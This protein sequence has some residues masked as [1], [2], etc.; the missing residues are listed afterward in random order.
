[1]SEPRWR[2]VGASVVGT[3]HTAH[4][5][6]CQ[7]AHAFDR[8]DLPAQGQVLLA[9]VADG[10]GSAKHA[11][12]GARIACASAVAA[13]RRYLGGGGRL[14]GAGE[15]VVA[16]WFDEA[17]DAVASAAEQRGSD[18]GEFAATLL[19]AVVGED[20][21]AFAQVGDGAVVAATADDEEPVFDLVVQPTRGEYANETV[22]ITTRGWREAL[23]HRLVQARV[24]DVA[25]MSDGVERLAID[26]RRGRPHGPFF[27][28]VLGP[29]WADAGGSGE[30]AEAVLSR[31][32]HE[33]LVSPDANRRTDDDKT[34]LLA[35][36]R[37]GARPEID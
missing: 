9:A 12:V 35:T 13:A 37:S 17:A 20:T 3:S 7:D 10:A 34:L 36:R 31:A 25:L 26:L 24:L 18:V 2:V 28:M 30:D 16:G 27:S 21:A 5:L 6:P 15:A 29:M 1:M 23:Q 19:F 22:F 4:G 14:S 32:L 33:L 8:L 11:E